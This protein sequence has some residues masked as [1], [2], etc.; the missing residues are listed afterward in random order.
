MPSR[1]RFQAVTLFTTLLSTLLT[2]ATAPRPAS[3]EEPLRIVISYQANL[4]WLQFGARA[5]GLF[6]KVGLAPKHVKF[7]AGAPMIAA[8]QSGDIDI[9]VPGI[10]PCVTGVGQGVDWVIIGIDAAGASSEGF[11][12]RQ[13]AGINSVADLKG[14]K[15]GYFRASTAHYALIMALRKHNIGLDQVQLLHMAPA[16][17]FA[18]LLNKNVDAIEVWEPWIQKALHEAGGKLVATEEDLGIHTAVAVIAV[19]RQWRANNRETARRY[20]TAMLL[21]QRALDKDRSPAIN[22]V[23][24]EMGVPGAWANA[25]YDVA[26][27]AIDR[28]LDPTYPY[29]IGPNG[30]LR[31]NLTEVARF[32]YDEKVITKPVDTTN[33]IDTS[34]VEEVLK[35]QQQ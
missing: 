21:A 28:W 31:K 8:A 32:L 5:L 15:I 12:A 1:R 29:S 30:A 25:S 9:A 35:S 27:P 33:L 2:L 10:V 6:Q 19:R 7:L 20:I 23:A 18:A 14:K 13:D 34:L 3:A 4:G 17:Q 24:E 16:Q 22:L 26:P 11:V